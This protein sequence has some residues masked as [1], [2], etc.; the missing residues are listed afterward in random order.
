MSID[1]STYDTSFMRKSRKVIKKFVW[2]IVPDGG[3]ALKQLVKR[4][5]DPKQERRG[6]LAFNESELQPYFLPLEKFT[7][8]TFSC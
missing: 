5:I 8:F 1:S 7:S 3:V 6:Y 4:L 2:P